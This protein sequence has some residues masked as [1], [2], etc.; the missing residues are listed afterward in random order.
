MSWR[1]PWDIEYAAYQREVEKNIMEWERQN[2]IR[3]REYQ[4]AMAKRYGWCTV[5]VRPGYGQ[6]AF[7]AGCEDE[8]IDAMKSRYGEEY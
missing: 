7:K 8:W 4:E 1:T 3:E 6:A 5:P 2:A